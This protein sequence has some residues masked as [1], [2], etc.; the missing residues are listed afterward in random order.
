MELR[1][2]REL[3]EYPKLRV[4]KRPGDNNGKIGSFVKLI[5]IIISI[6]ATI[7]VTNSDEEPEP[8]ET[9]QDFVEKS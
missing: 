2:Y 8:E 1:K 6:V 4:L 3:E 9:L 7:A 5:L